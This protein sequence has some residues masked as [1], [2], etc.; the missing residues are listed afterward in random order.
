MV[1]I[2]SCIEVDLTGQVNAESMGS[3]QFSGVG[4]QV[5]FVRG[6]RMSRGGRSI[7]AMPSTAAGGKVS[8]IVPALSSGAIVTTSRYD[9]DNIVTEYGVAALRGK[10]LR[11]RAIAL[12]S[13]A[14]PDFR[15][16]LHGEIERRFR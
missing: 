10:T 12:A 15:D 4:G 11:E 13:I 3:R 14:H 1:S 2:N 6:A 8:R 5:D 16:A 7:I 9:V